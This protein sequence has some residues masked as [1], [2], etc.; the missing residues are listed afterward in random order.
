MKG[1]K[2]SYIIHIQHIYMYIVRKKYN[3]FVRAPETGR[4]VS[5]IG[6][7][8][9]TTMYVCCVYPAKSKWPKQLTNSPQKSR[10]KHRSNHFQVRVSSVTSML[11]FY[12]FY[13][14]QVPGDFYIR[15][16]K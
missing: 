10:N 3:L 8:Y 9:S 12:H 2:K 6:E 4:K 15:Q 13:T 16:I 11:C 1:I 14:D 5:D 7:L